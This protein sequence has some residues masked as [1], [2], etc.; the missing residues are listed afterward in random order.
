MVP[1][2]RNCT[3]RQPYIRGGFRQQAPPPKQGVP[4][5]A[6]PDKPAC[7]NRNWERRPAGKTKLSS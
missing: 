2:Q 5:A 3:A 7:I 1:Q 6:R 4:D